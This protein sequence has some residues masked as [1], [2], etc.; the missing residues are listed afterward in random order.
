MSLSQTPAPSKDRI[1]G[2][3]VNP[4]GS[5]S[6]EK[7]A[8]QIKL[9]TS[10]IVSLTKKL[11]EFKETHKTNKVSLSDLKA[12]YRRGLGAYST[13]H[14]PN[15][16]RSGW[17]M[18]RVNAFLSKAG[19]GEHKKA[20]VQ[21]DDL[22]KMN[23]GGEVGQNI[24][25]RRCGWNWNT[26]DSEEFDKYVC[27]NCG[28][29]NRTFY[30]VDPIGYADGG[31][32]KSIVEDSKETGFLKFIKNAQFI[33]KHPELF[34]ADGGEVDERK[35]TYAKWK[36]LVN[37]S[38]GEIKK[39]YDSKEGKEAGLSSS[40]ANEQ[41]ISSGRESARWLMKMK[42]TPKDKWTDE[43]WKWANK[44]IS[45][46]SRMSGMQGELYDDKGN[47]T[48]KH[49]SLL[50]WGYNPKK[51]SS[52]KYDN[53]GNISYSEY[54]DSQFNEDIDR[55]LPSDYFNEFEVQN[56]KKNKY[57]LLLNEIGGIEYRHKDFSKNVIGAF[58]GDVLIGYADDKAIEVS[59]KYQKR[60]IG[61]NLI[62]LIKERNPEHRF[63]SMTPQG[64]NLMGSYYDKKIA[65]YENGGEL[66]GL[67]RSEIDT[68]TH[69]ESINNY[70]K[71]NE[72]QTELN[73]M[74]NK[75]NVYLH[76]N[77]KTMGTSQSFKEGG[78]LKYD[79]AN[80]KEYFAHGSG[81]AGGV[82]VGKRHSE[83]G[84]KA[85]NKSTGQPLEMEGGEVVITRKAVSDEKKREFEGEML[86]NKE[87]LSRINE[88][89]G[90]VKIFS[91]GGDIES[92]TCSCSGKS[93]KYGGK[94]MVDYDIA[95]Q[96]ANTD[97]Q[98]Y[99]NSLSH[100]SY[101][102]GGVLDINKLNAT[103]I[104][105]LHQL[106]NNVHNKCLVSRLNTLDLFY[107]EDLGMIY[108]TPK[109]GDSSCYEVR[110]TE[111]GK[112]VL[113]DTDIPEGHFAKGGQT[114]DCGCGK[115][116]ADG[117]IMAKGGKISGKLIHKVYGVEYYQDDSLIEP[118][119]SEK[120]F[121]ELNE[122]PNNIEK[123]EQYFETV[124]DEYSGK[125]K[126]EVA[127][128]FDENLKNGKYDYV[129]QNPDLYTSFDD[130]MADGGILK[131][132]K[133]SQ[134]SGITSIEFLDNN[135]T[136]KYGTANAKTNLTIKNLSIE[137]ILD[138][139]NFEKQFL[140]DRKKRIEN[141][142]EKLKQLENVRGSDNEVEFLIRENKSDKQQVLV[143]EKIAIPFLEY[144]LN[145]KK[146][147]S[148]IVNTDTKYKYF[149][150][151]DADYKNQFE[152]NKAIEELVLSIPS[153]QLT[154]E[155][156]NFISY[157]SGYGGLE[158]YGAT[159][160]GLLYEYFTPSKIAKKMW[161]LAYKY[162]FKG[163]KVLE[164][165]CGIGEFIKYA[166]EQEL[167]TGYEINEVSAK[168]CKI[169]YPKANIE[170]KYFETFFIKNNNS[171]R[172]DMKNLPKF[173]LIIGNP[174]YGTMGGIYAGMGE[175]SYTKSSNYIDYFINR[176][177]DLLEKDGLLIYIIGTEV[178]AGG[179]PFLMQ[180]MNEAKKIISQKANLLDAYRLPNGVFD[181]TDV[182]TD[183]IVLQKK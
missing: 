179:T 120:L 81:N 124:I 29:D 21:D 9:S 38:Y 162:G 62:T 27:H 61:L 180:Q 16:T 134:I 167:V 123:K 101:E 57:S 76:D 55:H 165:S 51:N 130:K 183:I 56:N 114:A 104:H 146:E 11:N 117:G 45:F 14:R 2:S 25:C 145:D 171:I 121:W 58:D 94:M 110:L 85:V 86:T 127:E 113:K 169:L 49:T 70:Q 7:S 31:K 41:G 18:G 48:R 159:G 53:G 108:S 69:N 173:S 166:P 109:K 47:K 75:K 37:M 99:Y 36:S 153:E 119:S 67:K 144:H 161:A 35:E 84:I 59:P 6:S 19:G 4:K 39:F 170:S 125:S 137:Q 160:K 132:I 135:K 90:G 72:M 115:S 73:L 122:L 78:N 43:M 64:F 17:A 139:L 15:I 3:K 156:K 1:Y 32:I 96:I 107:L 65:K 92:D 141:F 87:I 40:E 111:Y 158:K 23:N 46:I 98:A 152:I 168:I 142:E 182:V 175:K 68:N 8:E 42:T 34:L 88:S 10:I 52:M 28:F 83:G 129:G 155:E 13:S 50:I 181:T 66:Q 151:I 148:G 12:V 157:F 164:P 147:N 44:Q 131:Q 22:M 133:D 30:D 63:G 79:S 177:L 102:T 150:G 20:Y 89:G 33:Q 126:K 100:K 174:P 91:E 136:V 97:K 112:S 149:K 95:K 172:G 140:K 26:K 54:R 60:G 178:S 118:T 74:G 24:K 80:V 77:S 138:E 5:A 116:Y 154:A 143:A 163:G 176:G 103:E 105:V 93:Y 82:L 106:D 128:Y 71:S